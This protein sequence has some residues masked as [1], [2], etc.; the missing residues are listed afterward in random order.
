MQA[1]SPISHQFCSAFA[2]MSEHS[3]EIPNVIT[4]N[5]DLTVFANS[6]KSSFAIGQDMWYTSYPS[7][8]NLEYRDSA[9]NI[10]VTIS[11]LLRTT[12]PDHTIPICLLLI[13]KGAK[14]VDLPTSRSS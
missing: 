9:V 10:F 8:V 11:S 12:L 3:A 5:I 6:V 1:L 7:C 14:S 13:A 4:A 2:R